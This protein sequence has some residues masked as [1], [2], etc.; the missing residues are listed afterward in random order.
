MPKRMYLRS[1]ASSDIVEDMEEEDEEIIPKRMSNSITIFEDE[2]IQ[3]FDRNIEENHY[4]YISE[5]SQEEEIEN[6]IESISSNGEIVLNDYHVDDS[7]D[8]DQNYARLLQE[9]EI[10]LANA[11]YVLD[12]EEYYHSG[13]N[14]EQISLL[15]RHR[16]LA[17]A[18]RIGRGDFDTDIS[19]MSYEELIQ[20]SETIGEVKS[21]GLSETIIDNLPVAIY[22]KGNKG[23]IDENCVVCMNE[24][25]LQDKLTVLDCSHYF[26]QECLRDW[27]LR[28]AKCPVCR[29]EVRL[30]IIN[31]E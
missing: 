30:P 4:Q 17:L 21:R 13:E 18:F 10:A 15:T 7:D 23:K 8:S 26:H 27:L 20:L 16:D 14:N 1:E 29:I 3:E 28:Q 24:Y 2:E 19:E 25:Q 6:S 12:A 31:V 11:S 22:D 9:Q 5:T